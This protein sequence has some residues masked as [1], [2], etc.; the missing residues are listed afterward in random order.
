MN[1]HNENIGGARGM[2]KISSGEDQMMFLEVIFFK[3]YS[4]VIVLV[5]VK[6][7]VLVM[8]M[9]LVMVMVMPL[10]IVLVMVVV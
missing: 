1:G 8:V 7:I 10:V 9:T 2:V 4:M 3:G 5:M 6:I